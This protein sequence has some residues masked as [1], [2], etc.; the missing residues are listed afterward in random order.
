MTN[1]VAYDKL[2]FY[3]LGKRDPEFIH[4]YIVDAFAAQ[5]ADEETK[6]ITLTFALVGLYLH[7]EK[8]YSGREV[9]LAHMK[10]GKFKRDWPRFDI[11]INKGRIT[12][13]NVL[14]STE[15]EERDRLIQDWMRDVWDAY[16]ENQE[17]VR[18]LIKEYEN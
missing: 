15:G 1:Q 6:P 11:P 14:E 16:K 9:Q 5:N 18:N 17:Q 2:A 4:Q 13:F 10:M 12:V 8:N 3:T 7:I